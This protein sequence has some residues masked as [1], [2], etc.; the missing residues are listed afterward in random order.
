MKNAL[1]KYTKFTYRYYHIKKLYFILYYHFQKIILNGLLNYHIL[2]N[3][4]KDVYL[5]ELLLTIIY[6][7]KY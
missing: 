3:I 2:Q 5:M 7:K 4:L 6:L 1:N